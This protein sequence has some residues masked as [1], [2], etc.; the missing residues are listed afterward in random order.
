MISR[1][2][3]LLHLLLLVEEMWLEAIRL[4]LMYVLEMLRLISVGMHVWV[5]NLLH[6]LLVA[7]MLLLQPQL[8][9][10]KLAVLL[11]K[12]VFVETLRASLVLGAIVLYV[13][14]L[15]VFMTNIQGS[16]KQLVP[17]TSADMNVTTI[18]TIST[19]VLLVQTAHIRN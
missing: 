6:L 5:F 16:I 19:V 14:H 7:K 13:V 3:H 15:A 4:V 1:P 8:L 18:L 10:L 9:L 12:L 2:V 11:S 17:E